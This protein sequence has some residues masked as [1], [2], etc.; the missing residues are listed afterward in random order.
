MDYSEPLN[1]SQG[2]QWCHIVIDTC[3]N[4]SVAITAQ[5]A[6]SAHILLVLETNLCCV[7]SFPDNL[8]SAKSVTF[9]KNATQYQVESQDILQIFH[10]SYHLQASD[11]VEYWNGLLNNWLKNFL[12]ILPLPPPGGSK[13]V[14]S[15]NEAVSRNAAALFLNNNQDRRFVELNRPVF[16]T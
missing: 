5:P 6:D 12:T 11:L 14:W 15:L 3:S 9:I 1:Q 7:F 10:T 4:S 16:K 8:Q 2:Y 13:A